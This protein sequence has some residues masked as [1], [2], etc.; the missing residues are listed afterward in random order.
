MAISLLVFIGFL[1]PNGLK[2]EPELPDVKPATSA[3]ISLPIE[4][5]SGVPALK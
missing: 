3:F 5:G 4:R 2:N 1:P